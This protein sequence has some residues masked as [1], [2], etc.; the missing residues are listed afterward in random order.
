L[1]GGKDGNGET[2]KK[3]GEVE[4]EVEGGE[5]YSRRGEVKMGERKKGSI[6]S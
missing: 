3:A 1:L 2:T 6:K 5:L 4:V